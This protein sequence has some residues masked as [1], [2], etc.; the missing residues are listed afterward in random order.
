MVMGARWVGA[1]GFP[2]WFATACLRASSRIR[3]P[4]TTPEA[5]PAIHLR[6]PRTDP[7]PPVIASVA[8]APAAPAMTVGAAAPSPVTPSSASGPSTGVASTGRPPRNRSR[9]SR[10]S[11]ALEYRLAG[12]LAM[13]FSTTASRSAGTSGT[14]AVG[15]VGGSRTCL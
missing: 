6:R 7:D 8:P 14:I 9:S 3:S 10:I 12:F 15:A 5:T 4:S 2:G 13:A 11:L 1:G